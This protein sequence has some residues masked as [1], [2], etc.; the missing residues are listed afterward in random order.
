MKLYLSFAWRNLWRR[1]RR[2]F[3]TMASVTFAVLLSVLMVSLK[4]GFLDKMQENAVSIYTG[5]IQIHKQG[6]WDD[7]NLE[8]T[9]LQ[10][11]WASDSIL[12]N[13]QVTSIIPRLEAYALAAG[14]KRVK[15]SMVVALIL[16][17][18]KRSQ[19]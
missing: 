7:Q 3:I 1:K 6:Y 9:L 15:V 18:N 2:T 14:D 16:R 19:N 12:S 4:E 10:S 5:Y 8:N 11:K 17:K 13:P